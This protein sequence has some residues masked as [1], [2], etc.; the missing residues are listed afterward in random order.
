M[1]FI[2]ILICFKAAKQF[3]TGKK[4]PITDF[5]PDKR[6]R[7]GF[8]ELSRHCGGDSRE[9][10][11]RLWEA[12]WKGQ[13]SNDTFAVVRSGILSGFIPREVNDGRSRS[14]RGAFNRW[15]SS[16]PLVGNWY[17]LEQEA[18]A[19]RSACANGNSKRPGAPAS[20]KIRH[21]VPTTADQGTAAAPVGQT[22][23]G[24]SPDGAFR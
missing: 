23:Q 21:P 8:L 3:K 4:E 24:S 20:E 13:V 18:D 16:R 5:F 6:G 12:A 1:P 11:Q 15:K 7:Y 10:A 17:L 14:R 22:L 9:T 2:R 19:G